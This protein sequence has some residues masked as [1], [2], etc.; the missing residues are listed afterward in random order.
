MGAGR[1]F[2]GQFRMQFAVTKKHRGTRDEDISS[3][4]LARN[5]R[6]LP[7]ICIDEWP[8]QYRAGNVRV[9]FHCA[10]RTND[11]LP[12]HL[13]EFTTN[14][15]LRSEERRVGKDCRYRLS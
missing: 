15:N 3:A 1:G 13:H 2:T 5:V 4:L 9:V 12:A 10:V 8:G 6:L 14:A 7:I 11:G